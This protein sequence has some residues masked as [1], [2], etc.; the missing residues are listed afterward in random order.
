MIERFLI[1]LS[2]AVIVGA[3]VVAVRAWSGRRVAA[4]K[5]GQAR[6]LWNALGE[7]PDGRPSLVVFSTP[8][9]TACRTAQHPAVE[10]VEA[11]FGGALRIL[12]IDLSRRPAVGHAFK[13]LT[14]P[15]TVVLAG[16][17]RVGSFN[18]GFAPADQLAAQV[19]AVAAP[20]SS[21]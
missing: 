10:A 6:G 3:A 1:V 7:S 15:T 14:A 13:V 21:R 19:S 4:L 2:L 17:G 9:C 11:R 8:S 12:K 5:A 18:H 16:D 20:A